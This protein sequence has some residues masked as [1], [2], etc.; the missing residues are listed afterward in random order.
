[1][2]YSARNFVDQSARLICPTGW[3]AQIVSSPFCKNILLFRRRKSPHNHRRPVPHE[4]R[5]AIV[6]NAGRDAV[7][8]A[9]S[10]VPLGSQGGLLS[11]SETR[12]ARRTTLTR[13]AKACGPDA[14]TPASSRAEVLRARPGERNHIRAATVTR[15]PDHRGERAISRKAIAWGC[16]MIPVNSL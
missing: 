6:T 4:G 1:M 2:R 14:S 12:H 3:P 9:A 11:V 15:K 5:F 8:A 10:G 13:T 7:D 16:R